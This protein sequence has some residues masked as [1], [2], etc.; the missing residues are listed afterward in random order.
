MGLDRPV[1]REARKEKRPK[2]PLRRMLKQDALYLMV[3]N[4]PTQAEMDAIWTE[5]DASQ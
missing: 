5:M 3:V 2:G 4:M 1:G